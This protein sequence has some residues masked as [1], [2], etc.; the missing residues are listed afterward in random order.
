MRRLVSAVTFLAVLSAPAALQAGDLEGVKQDN[1]N[2]WAGTGA[3]DA[4]FSAVSI[5]MVGWGV[6]L[7]GGI[8][9]LASAIHQSSSSHDSS[10]CSH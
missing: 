8:A 9:L 1:T 6:G 10:S 2:L 5:S 4:T 7:A 3:Q